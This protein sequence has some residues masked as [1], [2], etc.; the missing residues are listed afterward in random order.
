MPFQ[1]YFEGSVGEV[2]GDPELEGAVGLAR[3]MRSSPEAVHGWQ[4]RAYVRDGIPTVASVHGERMYEANL[5]WLAR[6]QAR[7]ASRPSA[8]DYRVEDSDS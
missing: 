8:R 1:Q 2:H 3:A 6:D 5:A 7:R 4:H